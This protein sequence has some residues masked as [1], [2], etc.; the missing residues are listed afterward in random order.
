MADGPDPD[1]LAANR[2]GVLSGHQHEDLRRALEH[3][4]AGL[5]GRLLHRHDD[6]ALDV[7]GGQVA[8]TEGMIRKAHNPAVS[9][10]ARLTSADK[11]SHQ[12]VIEGPG[13]VQSFGAGVDLWG[14]AP[15]S[16]PVRLYYLPRSRWAIN[17]EPIADAGFTTGP[18]AA[19][20]LQIPVVGPL[21][22]AEHTRPLAEGLVG[23]WT[24]PLLTATFRED[25][26]VTG[27]VAGRPPTDG[28]WAVTPDGRLHVA[29]GDWATDVEAYVTTSTLELVVDGNAIQLS[30]SLSPNQP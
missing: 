19:P 10:A 14:I 23:N 13:G 18:L 12:L 28:T 29:L 21:G 20:P 22:G 30:R 6:F 17:L 8:A 2:Q 24:S 25:G 3:R 16:G 7:E 15:A 5:A 1:E 27:S 11:A 26:T 9:Q 4:S